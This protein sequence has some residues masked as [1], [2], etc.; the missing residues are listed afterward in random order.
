MGCDQLLRTPI[1]LAYTRSLLRF[2]WLW[3][4]LLPFSLVRTFTDFGKGTWWE[5]KPLVVVP[6][7]TVFIGLGFL[8]LEDIA[9]QIE[10]PF[11]VQR[12]KLQRLSE[13]FEQ[14]AAEMQALTAQLQ[15][16]EPYDPVELSNVRGSAAL[17]ALRAR[18]DSTDVL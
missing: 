14:D 13:W 4:T 15:A 5:G 10:E 1:P 17:G 12:L 6:V 7:V 9:V 18:M 8:S 16:V 11:M 3:L 2:L